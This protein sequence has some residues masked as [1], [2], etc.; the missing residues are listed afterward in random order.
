MLGFVAFQVV[1]QVA[2]YQKIYGRAQKRSSAELR[3]ISF[4]PLMLMCRLL[5]PRTI[6]RKKYD[7][8]KAKKK[9]EI[10]R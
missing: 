1:D 9:L 6:R 10:F 3:K 5:G 7:C 2:A 8:V 4:A